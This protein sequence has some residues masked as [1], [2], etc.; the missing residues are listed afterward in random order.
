MCIKIIDLGLVCT[1]AEMI[2][3]SCFFPHFIPFSPS[4]LLSFQCITRNKE[5]QKDRPRF[6]LHESQKDWFFPPLILFY[7]F[8][9]LLSLV[10]YQRGRKVFQN[11]ICS[12]PKDGPR[13]GLY[14]IHYTLDC[15]KIIHVDLGLVYMKVKKI[16]IVGFFF[17]CLWTITSIVTIPVFVFFI[18]TDE[19]LF[20]HA[21]DKFYLVKK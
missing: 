5:S 2:D 14:R 10:C 12:S 3:L 8:L 17:S 20:K 9:S 15:I 16:N 19:S 11:L 21:D 6:G 1:R 7:S 4:S 13:F 18:S